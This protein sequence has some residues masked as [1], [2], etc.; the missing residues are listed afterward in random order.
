[1]NLKIAILLLI[2]AIILVPLLVVQII[3]TDSPQQ[4]VFKSRIIEKLDE[5]LNGIQYSLVEH[6]E[7]SSPE[8]EFVVATDR[9]YSRGLSKV[10][11]EKGQE[12]WMQ[13]K[14]M[15]RD[16]FGG[17]EYPYFGRPQIYVSQ[18]KD[19]G[20]WPDQITELRLLYRS[21][22]TSPLAPVY[23]WFFLFSGEGAFLR[24]F[25][26]LIAQTIS[27]FA[28]IF[29]VVKNRKKPWNLVLILLSYAFLVM[30]LTIPILTDLY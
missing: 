21:P 24:P 9:P 13:G 17:E 30:I 14:L 2:I 10:N 1:M 12:L 23:L 4:Y 19:R 25:L 5:T 20:F 15:T 11:L 26:V 28:A 6:I 8:T 27:I 16:T 22:I 18:I 29:L 7:G 3:Q